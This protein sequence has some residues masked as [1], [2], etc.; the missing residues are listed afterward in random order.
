MRVRKLLKD[1]FDLARREYTPYPVKHYV[2]DRA[3][4]TREIFAGV[5]VALTL[6]GEGI[7][8]AFILHVEPQIALHASWIVGLVIALLGSRMGMVN[9]ADGV[10]AAALGSFILANGVRYLFP[11]VITMSVLFFI[12]A[13]LNLMRFVRMIPNTVMIGFVNGL[14]LII[15]IGQIAHFKVHPTDLY[16]SGP[17]LYWM[18]FEVALTVIVTI[19]LP[20][21][22]RIGPVLPSA[23]IAMGI[24]TLFDSVIL[25]G[26]TK[27]STPTIG[28]VSNLTTGPPLPFW[29]D[30]Q[31]EGQRVQASWDTFTLIIGPS[32][33]TAGACFVE[34]VM[35]ME[36]VDDL[37]RTTNDKP[38]Q[39]IF[40][41][42]LANLIAGLLGTMGG[43]A[44]IPETV[45][46]IVVAGANGRYRIS[47]IVSSLVILIFILVAQDFI[48]LIPTASIVG[49]MLIVVFHTF[50]WSSLPII[51]ASF[52]P[53]QVR[54][55]VHLLK[56]RKV[57]RFDAA[58]IIVV[59]VVVVTVNLFIAVLAGVLLTSAAI[60]WQ[61]GENL[62]I[63]P[64]T[65]S[66]SHKKVYVVEG[67]LLFSATKRFI[68]SF[69]PEHD[70][71]EVEV[72]FSG[73]SGLALQD[74]ASIHA[75]NVVGKRYE[76]IGKSFAVGG[77][78]EMSIRRLKKADTLRKHFTVM[79]QEE[80][81][82]I[83]DNSFPRV[84]EVPV[85]EVQVGASSMTTTV[86]NV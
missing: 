31:Y 77:L 72:R 69:D 10:R 64:T 17:T 43:A 59:T 74:F 29:T 62:V 16:Q 53:S 24:C 9:G 60:V 37:T 86:V 3:Q 23:L 65:V 6:V 63:R 20:C 42:S 51:L 4:V 70:P 68:G 56:T 52:M 5:S 66:D 7:A 71:S 75:L 49:I 13:I 34:T 79:I 61:S 76:D 45:F 21:I 33:T 46:N 14:A 55:R 80:E 67:P 26:T 25:R 85:S 30:P 8:F 83:N 12:A 78:D 15:F 73:F 32:I 35:T 81:E 84:N 50:D 18:L 22:P 41:M 36:V 2:E 40:A 39:Q 54:D 11:V 44:L 48:K 19:L 38:R 58:V 82:A 47:G 1:G 57:N 28:T 27:W